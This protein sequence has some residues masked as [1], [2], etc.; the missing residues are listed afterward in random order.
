M[1]QRRRRQSLEESFPRQNTTDTF[2]LSTLMHGLTFRR[3]HAQ[4]CFSEC[5]VLPRANTC[6]FHFDM[7]KCFFATVNLDV[8]FLSPKALEDEMWELLP[9]MSSWRRQSFVRRVSMLLVWH[10]QCNV[11]REL[12]AQRHYKTQHSSIIAQPIHSVNEPL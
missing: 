9:F 6:I 7:K 10:T 12:P 4:L 2:Y 3:Q 5:H 8:A 11:T 1:L